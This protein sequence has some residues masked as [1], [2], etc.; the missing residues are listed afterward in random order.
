LLAS[1]RGGPFFSRLCGD[2]PTIGVIC[3]RCA[4]CAR[5]VPSIAH[6]LV[7]TKNTNLMPPSSSQPIL[8]CIQPDCSVADIALVFCKE[9]NQYQPVTALHHPGLSK[10]ET[11]VLSCGTV[12]DGR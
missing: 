5:R 4:S 3:A 1:K 12:M 6:V 8:T 2:D 10:N 11:A 9:Q 7:I